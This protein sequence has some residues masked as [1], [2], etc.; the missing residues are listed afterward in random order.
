MATSTCWPCSPVTRPDHSPST[1]ACPSSSSPSSRKN[2]I[3]GARSSTTMPTLSIRSAICRKLQRSLSRRGAQLQVRE[4]RV[5]H[6]VSGVL[7]AQVRGPQ[8]LAKSRVHS[9]FQLCCLVVHAESV[10]EHHR[11]GEE[12]GERVRLAGPGDVGCRA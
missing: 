5:C 2:S 4:N 6:L 9:G 10:L 12:R 7:A 11:D 8:P 1:V 3:A